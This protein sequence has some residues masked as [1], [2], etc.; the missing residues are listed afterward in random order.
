MTLRA[1]QSDITIEWRM[2]AACR[3]TDPALFFPIG[4]TGPAIEQIASAKEVCVG[5]MARDDCLDFAI[6]TNQDSGVWGGTT[7]E[8]RRAIRRRLRA[9][10]I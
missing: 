1:E 9:A 3:D 4:T 5:C 8:E 7:E 10:R 2:N 6:A